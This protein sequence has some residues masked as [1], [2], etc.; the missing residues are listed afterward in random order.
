MTP[1]GDCPFCALPDERVPFRNASALAVRDAYPVNPGHTL[2]ISVRHVASFFD[3]TPAERE[4]MLEL[5]DAAK[6]QVRSSPSSALPAK[7]SAPSMVSQRGR[8]S[9]TCRC[10]RYLGTPVTDSI[11]AAVSGG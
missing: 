10:T 8:Q 2:V 5:L 11:H 3:A 1:I 6:K 7:T 4:S 9:V